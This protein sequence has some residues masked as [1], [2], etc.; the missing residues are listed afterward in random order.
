[1]E[2]F[3]PVLTACL[4]AIEKKKIVISMGSSLFG[5]PVE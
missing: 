2:P 5:H 4:I 3:H 1:M